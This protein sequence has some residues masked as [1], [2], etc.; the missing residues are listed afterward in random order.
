[1]LFGISGGSGADTFV[2][3]S[4]LFSTRNIELRIADFVLDTD[5]ISLDNRW[6]V[7]DDLAAHARALS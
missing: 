6:I 5:K 7:G 4:L 1:M 3:S 2:F